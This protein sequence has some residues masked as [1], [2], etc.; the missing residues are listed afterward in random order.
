[1]PESH[2]Q[3]F[4]IRRDQAYFR[5]G[6]IGLFALMLVKVFL[7]DLSRLD[8]VYRILSFVVL[9]GVLVLVSFLYTRYRERLG[10][11]AR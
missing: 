8:A 10:Q 11:G 3:P 9:G 4:G 5:A 1:V 7:V 2:R 6:L